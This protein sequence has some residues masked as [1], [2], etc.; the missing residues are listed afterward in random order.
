MYAW[1]EKD[2]LLVVHVISIAQATS[3]GVL[4]VCATMSPSYRQFEFKRIGIRTT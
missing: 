3:R 4:Q 1:V 2:M